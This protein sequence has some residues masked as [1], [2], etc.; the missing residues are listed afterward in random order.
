MIRHGLTDEESTFIRTYTLTQ[1]RTK[2]RH[3][4][5]VDTVLEA[6]PGRPGPGQVDAHKVIL[7][8]CRDEGRSVAELAGLLDR[9]ITAVKVLVSDLIDAHALTVSVTG[10]YAGS[11]P[12]GRPTT[13]LLAALAAGLKRKWPNAYAKAG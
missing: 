13:D 2:A 7:G 5:A 11:E 8:L 3:L 12:D 6:G 1:G 10:A 9:P 4:L